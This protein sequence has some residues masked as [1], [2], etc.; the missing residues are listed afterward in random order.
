MAVRSPS[1]SIGA[2]SRALG[3]QQ[4]CREV[5]IR[6]AVGDVVTVNTQSHATDE[7]LKALADEIVSRRMVL[8]D[9]DEY[10]RLKAAAGETAE[11]PA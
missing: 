1:E 5:T 6:I 11:A 4:W 7:Q 3:L 10:A 8:V 2:L 9:A